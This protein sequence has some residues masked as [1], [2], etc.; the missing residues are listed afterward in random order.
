M[1]EENNEHINRVLERAATFAE[2]N[3]HEYLTAEHLL[4]SLLQE[5]DVQS[6]ITNV[7]SKPSIIR[8]SVEKHINNNALKVPPNAEIPFKGPLQTTALRRIFQRALTNFI[9]SGRSEITG[10]G[11]LLSI[12]CEENSHA[13]Y[14]L[15]KGGVTRDRVINYMK[16]HDIDGASAEPASPLE[17]FCRNLNKASKDG[18]VDP[19]VGR[20]EELQDTIEVLARRKK[21]NI[22][23][24]GHPGVGKTCLAEGLA[25]KIVDEEVPKALQAKEVYSLDIGA[26]VAGTKYRGDFEERLK[27]V[28]KEIEKKGNVI[29]FIDEIHMIMGAGSASQGTMDASNMLKPMLAKGNLRCVGA[30][31]L[32]EYETHFEKDKALK[33]R[34]QRYEIAEP[35]I[36]DSKRIL[37]GLVGYYEKFHGVEYNVDALDHA[38][39]LSVRYLKNKHLPDKAIDIMDAA[40]AKAKLDEEEYVGLDR[41][42]AA[43]SKMA[44][45]P[46]AMID[47]KENDAI[48]NL[49]AKIKDSVYGQDESID[50]VVEA[51]IISKS[52]LR[53]PNKPVGSYLCVGPTGVGKTYFAKQLS[54]AL[55]V[56]MV[57][58]DMSEYSER[59]S[60]A[61]LIGA[62]PGYVGHGEGQGGSGQLITQVEQ[63]PNCV[64]LLDEVEKAAPEVLQVLLQVMDDGRL[65]SSTGKTVDFTNTILLMTSNLGARESEKLTIGFGDQKKV[66]ED[67]K[68]MKEF[69]APEFRNRLDGVLKF[70]KLSKEEMRLIVTRQ[71]DELNDVLSSKGVRVTCL[72][73]ARD[74]L[75]ENGYDEALGARPLARLMQDVIKKPIARAILFGD[76]QGGG[77]AR[78]AV[79]DNEIAITYR[80]PGGKSPTV[81]DV[82]NEEQSKD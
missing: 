14:F 62:P 31:T 66:G 37:R 64:L 57:R 10:I 56:E 78:L 47:I 21:N 26:L 20:E 2:E 30:T 65:T 82:L 41:I 81:N 24:V 58:F 13:Y 23:Y 80:P 51:I 15:H 61:R 55:G 39:D 42:I 63:H 74:W 1:S 28:L 71:I 49:D 52:G 32:D 38:V 67:D 43:V 22:I 11:L 36:D 27:A 48:A 72:A 12:M 16:K 75:A 76:L 6:I 4:W 3:D 25:K 34:F 70:G 19:V 46:A 17:E 54:H 59:H 33:R 73:A 40:G 35:S 29:L 60:I 5:R 77:K 68:A 8:N 50:T 7:G 69:F 18:M 53:D 45:I 79:V 9:F 44:K